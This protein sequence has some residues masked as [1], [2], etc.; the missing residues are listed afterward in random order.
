MSSESGFMTA[1]VWGV[2]GFG[3]D[4]AVDDEPRADAV[5]VA[6][7]GLEAGEDG[8]RGEP[9]G[10]LRSLERHFARNLAERSGR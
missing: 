8:E 10:V 6:E 7:G 9:C 3:V 2:A 5:E 4:V 1:V